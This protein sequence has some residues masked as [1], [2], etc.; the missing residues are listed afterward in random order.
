VLQI[1][2]VTG[3]LRVFWLEE[4]LTTH[5]ACLVLVSDGW[6]LLFDH[7]IVEQHFVFSLHCRVQ[8]LRLEQLVHDVIAHVLCHTHTMLVSQ[9]VVPQSLD[10]PAAAVYS[11]FLLLVCR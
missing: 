11:H 1:Q 9:H 8:Q 3:W 5:K 6:S 10:V 7:M 4:Y 2:H